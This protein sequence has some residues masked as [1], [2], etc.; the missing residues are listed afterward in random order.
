[1][2][3]APP[4]WRRTFD[5]TERLVGRP[6]EDAMT[7]RE[8]TDV[9]VGAFRLQKHLLGLFEAYTRAVWHFW[10]LPARSDVT[11]L[12]RQ[13]AALA[14]EVRELSARLEEEREGP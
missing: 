5:R 8:F 4:L 11:R 3:S 1:M 14:T 12:Q 10:N 13:L 6:L 2:S 9:L 7:T